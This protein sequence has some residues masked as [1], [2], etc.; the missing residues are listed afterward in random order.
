MFLCIIQ[1][2][3]GIDPRLRKKRKRDP[4]PSISFKKQN[5]E[6]F[7][8]YDKH[9]HKTGTV[10][11]CVFMTLFHSSLL[12]NCFFWGKKNNNSVLCFDLDQ[13]GGSQFVTPSNV[14]KFGELAFFYFEV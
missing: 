3:A 6:G 10:C 14:A 1:R 13:A 12:M 9:F 7:P 8:G 5:Q 11:L 4:S 2:K